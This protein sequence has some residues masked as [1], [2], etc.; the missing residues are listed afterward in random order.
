MDNCTFTPTSLSRSQGSAVRFANQSATAT[1]TLT[2]T[3]PPGSSDAFFSLEPGGTSGPYVLNVGG[4]YVFQC[5]GAGTG[6][7]VITAT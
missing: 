7:V 6:Q 4:T 3:G 5:R 1:I 2:V